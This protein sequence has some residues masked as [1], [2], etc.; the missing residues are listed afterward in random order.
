MPISKERLRLWLKLLKA[1]RHVESEIRRRMRSE[2]N[3][4][5]PRF[6]VMASLA[7]APEGLRMSG[8]SGMLKV[9]NGNVT[10]IVDKLVE[11]GLAVREAVPGDR[12]A[13]IVRLTDK[14]QEVFANHA[15]V[16]ETWIDEILGGLSQDDVEGMN[17]RLDHLAKHLDEIVVKD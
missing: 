1:S 11:E 15:A 13:S 4:T 12:R 10:V 5:L 2:F 17:L 7:R 14:G 6:D 16:H 8:I 9:S 3:S